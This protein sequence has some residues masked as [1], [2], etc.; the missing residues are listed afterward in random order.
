[1]DEKLIEE[2]ALVIQST[3]LKDWASEVFGNSLEN[4]RR[5]GEEHKSKSPLLFAKKRE[6]PL[7]RAPKE[8]SRLS[9]S[10]LFRTNV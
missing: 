6:A 10:I 7:A 4:G 9:N 1:L 2:I 8:K 5:G 3:I